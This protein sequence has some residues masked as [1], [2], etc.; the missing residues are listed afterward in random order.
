MFEERGLIAP[1]VMIYYSLAVYYVVASMRGGIGTY[2]IILFKM[3]LSLRGAV[4]QPDRP[5]AP[6]T[7]PSANQLLQMPPHAAVSQSDPS[8]VPPMQQGMFPNTPHT[9][10]SLHGRT[11]AWVS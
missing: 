8:D 5:D 10:L 4:S 2:P 11:S 1:K 6:L 7:Q 3:E 9:L